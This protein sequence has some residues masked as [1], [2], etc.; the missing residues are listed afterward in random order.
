MTIAYLVNQYPHVSHTFIRREIAALEELGLVIERFSIR[1]A[2]ADLVD[3]ADRAEVGRTR[4]I[5]A[6]GVL[7]LLAAMVWAVAHSPFGFLRAFA[8]AW[9]IGRRSD[10][11][12]FVHLIYLAEAAW[13]KLALRGATH[14]HAHFASDTKRFLGRSKRHRRIARQ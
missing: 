11:G 5:L 14:L 8:G 6:A 10:R 2:P 4:V 1:P 7:K 9:R 12:V 13:L 3:P